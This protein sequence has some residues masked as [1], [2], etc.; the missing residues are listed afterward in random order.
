MR[1]IPLQIMTQTVYAIVL[2]Y[3]RAPSLNCGVLKVKEHSSTSAVI[4]HWVQRSDDLKMSR[5]S[6]VQTELPVEKKRDFNKIMRELSH[7]LHYCFTGEHRTFRNLRIDSVKS[8]Y[9]KIK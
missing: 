5:T 2:Y 4:S 6:L 3:G 7:V 1:K 8:L 9:K